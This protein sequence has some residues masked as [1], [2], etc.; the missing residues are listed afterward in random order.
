MTKTCHRWP[1]IFFHKGPSWPDGRMPPEI[2]KRIFEI[3]WRIIPV[4][5]PFSWQQKMA[6]IPNDPG[7]I[8]GMILEKQQFKKIPGT[9]PASNSLGF[10]GLNRWATPRW[11]VDSPIKGQGFPLA[12][13]S[14]SLC[15]VKIL[16][17]YNNATHDII[18]HV[19]IL[20]YAM[21][22]YVHLVPILNHTYTYSKTSSANYNHLCCT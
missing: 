12:S 19:M 16:Y 4:S 10:G 21:S 2:T 15:N 22:F 7:S 13:R 18:L 9:N 5:D 11:K 17:I 3:T 6:T 20:W 8:L 1:A 14:M